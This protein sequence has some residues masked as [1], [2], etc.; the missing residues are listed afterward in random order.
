MDSLQ[1]DVLSAIADDYEE[2]GTIVADLR[3][4]HP[5]ADTTIDEVVA[6]LDEL[7]RF[8]FAGCYELSTT[9]PARSVIFERSR[10]TDFFFYIT[11]EGKKTLIS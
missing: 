11:E 9:A 7:V 1:R 2:V 3:C 10:A 5:K 4:W 6:A 8:G